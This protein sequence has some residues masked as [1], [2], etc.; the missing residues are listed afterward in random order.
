MET[1]RLSEGWTEQ[2]QQQNHE[3]KRENV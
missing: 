1:S 3:N 2:K